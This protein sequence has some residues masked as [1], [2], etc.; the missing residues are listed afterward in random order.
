VRAF[1]VAGGST[2]GGWRGARRN[3]RRLGL[4]VPLRRVGLLMARVHVCLGSGPEIWSSNSGFTEALEP[5]QSSRSFSSFSVTEK[6]HRRVARALGCS[7]AHYGRR[8]LLPF[9]LDRCSKMKPSQI[10]GQR[11]R[12]GQR[13]Q[14]EVVAG[15]VRAGGIVGGMVRRRSGRRRREEEN[16]PRAIGSSR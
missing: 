12:G 7:P 9:W 14:R 8:F 16:A 13:P 15:A 5:K 10:E 3:E 6:L 4:S 11:G 2:A 1:A